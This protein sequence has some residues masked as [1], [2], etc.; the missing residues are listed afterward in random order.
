MEIQRLQ[1]IKKKTVNA[2]KNHLLNNENFVQKL[3]SRIFITLLYSKILVKI[4]RPL[5]ALKIK[6]IFL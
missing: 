3:V 5:L 6:I 4:T 2:L 1:I